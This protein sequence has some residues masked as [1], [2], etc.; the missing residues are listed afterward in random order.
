M[1]ADVVLINGE[2]ITV[3][4]KNAVVEAVAIKDNQI[5]VVGS[6][7]EVKSFIGENTD[8]IDLQGK[9][10][11]PGFIDSHLH[12]ISHG[13]NQLAVS[14]KAEHIDSIDALL[15]DLKKKA[16]ET[17]KVNGYVLG[18]LMKPLWRKSVIQQL[19]SWMK[20]QLNILLL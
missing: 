16:L 3:D 11:L 13:L 12:I 6:N 20:F 5:V 2:V 17:P 1:K 7:Q 4:Q 9:T 15:D 19:L 18:A 14:C 8:V 10:L